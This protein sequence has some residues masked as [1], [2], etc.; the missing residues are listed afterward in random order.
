[1]LQKGDVAWVNLEGVTST[2]GSPDG[3]GVHVRGPAR[4]RPGAGHGRHR[5]GDH[6]QQPLRGL[7]P[8]GAQGHHLAAGECRRAGRRRRQGLRGRARAGCRDHS[9][10]RHRRLPG[11]QRRVVAGV[12]G[13]GE[14]R[15]RGP[16]VH[17][18]QADEAGHQRPLRQGGL[19][20]R[21]LPLGLRVP[22]LPRLPADQRGA[23]G[24]RRRRRPRHR[25]PPARAP[26][27]R[28]LQAAPHRV[29]PWRPGVRPHL[30]PVR[31]DR[32][33]GRH[34]Q[35]RRR[36]GA[37]G[38]GLRVAGR[39]PRHPARR[40]G[41]DHPRARQGVLR[42]RSTRRSGSTATSAT[43]APAR[44]RGAAAG[45][46]ASRAPS[47]HARA[48]GAHAPALVRQRVTPPRSAACGA[49]ARRPRSR[50][51]RPPPRRCPR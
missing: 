33:G 23:R 38:A 22:A 10:R 28:D 19:R 2:L 27:I 48:S 37:A 7:R 43:S 15:R 14:P 25:P 6:G 11:L 1:M 24:H 26:G 44:S 29:Q 8:R 16:G 30:G 40:R 18:H 3:E 41:A 51:S 50:R 36:D 39:H 31:P 9:L 17:R 35:A 12:R 45:P 13:H 46:S 47:G 42:R 20:G 34:T 21:R 32:A 49:S 4:V 5:R